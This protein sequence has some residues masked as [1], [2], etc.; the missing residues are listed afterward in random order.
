M[1]LH[2]YLHNNKLY[3]KTKKMSCFIDEGYS[4]DCRNASTGGL[5]TI[6]ILGNSGNTITGWTENIDEAITAISGSG[7]FYK[8]ELVKESS[9][10]SEAIT[11]NTTAQSVVF[12]P[13]LTINLPKLTQSLRNLFQNLVAQNNIFAIVKDNNNRYWSFAFSNGGLVTA[14]AIQSGT[15]YADL[16]GLSAL[17]IVGGE[18]DASQEIIVNTTLAAIMTGITVNAE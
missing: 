7:T 17:T 9:S 13:T 11:V 2:S 4:L 16:N 10:F 18:P 1:L 6:W 3:K 5:K 8:F 14:G 12:E 15:A